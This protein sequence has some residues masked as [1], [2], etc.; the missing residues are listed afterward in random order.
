MALRRHLIERRDCSDCARRSPVVP[1]SASLPP[2]QDPWFIA[3]YYGACRGCGEDIEP[4]DEIR[5]DGRGGWEGRCCDDADPAA[6]TGTA[7][8]VAYAFEAKGISDYEL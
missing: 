1:D 8:T 2:E 4:G 3:G 6:V 5:A 7:E